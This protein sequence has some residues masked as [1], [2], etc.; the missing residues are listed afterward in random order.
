MHWPRARRI[1]AG[2]LEAQVRRARRRV[3]RAVRVPVRLA[4]EIAETSSLALASWQ[5]ARTQSDFEIFR[6]L[7]ERMI[8]LKRQ[9]AEAISSQGSPFDVLL[10]EFEPGASEAELM[11]L[12]A[13]LRAELTP[14]VAAVRSTGIEVDETPARGRFEVAAQ[15][16]FGREVAQAMGFDFEAGRLDASTHP[17]CTGIGRQDVR[18]TWRWQEDDFRPALFGVIHE[19]AMD[20]TSRACQPCGRGPRSARRCHSASTSRSRDSGRTR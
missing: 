17:F 11:P 19:R 6:P 18:M 4:K 3:D 7:L 13:E 9:E 20:S 16:A 2:E 8:G 15:E 12:F 1:R 14:I 10:D 5:E